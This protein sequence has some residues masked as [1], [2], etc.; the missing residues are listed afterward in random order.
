MSPY[1]HSH[2]NVAGFVGVPASPGAHPGLYSLHSFSPA[3]GDHSFEAAPDVD[4]KSPSLVSLRVKP[5]EP[6][7][8]LNWTT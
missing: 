4:Y 5:K 8:L 6:P 7:S 3:L 1:T 2:G